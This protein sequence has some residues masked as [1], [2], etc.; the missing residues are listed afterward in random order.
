MI[1]SA[2]VIIY[3]NQK[4]NYLNAMK[5]VQLMVGKQLLISTSINRSGTLI[6]D[7]HVRTSDSGEASLSQSQMPQADSHDIF[8]IIIHQSMLYE[9]LSNLIDSLLLYYDFILH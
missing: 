2:Q 3:G 7:Q 8:L 4:N 6:I 1:Q 5:A 9:L